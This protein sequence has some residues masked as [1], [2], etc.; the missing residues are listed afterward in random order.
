M[1]E[2]SAGSRP[3]AARVPRSS[4]RT[5]ALLQVAHCSQ[6]GREPGDT[7]GAAPVRACPAGI[8]R[9]NKGRSGSIES[10]GESVAIALRQVG[11]GVAKIE[12]ERLV[13]EANTNIPGIVAGVGNAA[14][15]IAQRAVDAVERIRRAK[16][17][18]A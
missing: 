10:A 6:V 3:G 9:R 8:D 7:G 18:S 17:L 16:P 11:V 4:A 12:R 13:S 15:E 5:K 14:A 2:I 1:R